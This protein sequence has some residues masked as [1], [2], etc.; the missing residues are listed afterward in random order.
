MLPASQHT[1]NVADLTYRFWSPPLS[2]RD[3]ML[4]FGGVRCEVCPR[5]SHLV[6]RPGWKNAY[7]QMVPA[8]PMPGAV[9]PSVYLEGLEPYEWTQEELSEAEAERERRRIIRAQA[10]LA[11]QKRLDDWR[12][13][14]RLRQVIHPRQFKVRIRR[15]G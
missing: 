7:W 2:Q 14:D 3:G 5:R 13:W 10:D 4:L 6:Q 8:G 1:C 9:G 12:E 11:T 15:R